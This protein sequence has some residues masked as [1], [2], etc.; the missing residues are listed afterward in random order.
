MMIMGIA[1]KPVK[2][3]MMMAKIA[4]KPAKTQIAAN[5]M[6]EAPKPPMAALWNVAKM[7]SA[8]RGWKKDCTQVAKEPEESGSVMRY[9]KNECRL[10]CGRTSGTKTEPVE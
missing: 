3:T 2:P 7:P 4:R 5:L 8:A 9:I 10:T 6:R 1:R